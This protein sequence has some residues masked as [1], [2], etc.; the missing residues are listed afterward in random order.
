MPFMRIVTGKMF[1]GIEVSQIRKSL[2]IFSA[3]SRILS[4]S[5]MNEGARWQF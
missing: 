5:G 3:F 2:L 4:R 1:E